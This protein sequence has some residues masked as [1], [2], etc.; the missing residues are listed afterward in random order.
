MSN[1]P[2]RQGRAIE[3]KAPKRVDRSRTASARRGAG[4]SIF[5]DQRSRPTRS[6]MPVPRHLA[7]R[8]EHQGHQLA[9]REAGR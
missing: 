9:R 3:S 7:K 8:A 2:A 6:A 4:M 5:H 1:R